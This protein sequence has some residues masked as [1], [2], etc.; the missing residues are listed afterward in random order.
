M[1]ERFYV[2]AALALILAIFFGVR[3]R[4]MPPPAA[5]LEKQGHG[6]SIRAEPATSR[7]EASGLTRGGVI[8]ARTIMLQRQLTIHE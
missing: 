3:T 5:L 8:N 4:P 1:G 6:P 7:Q 2:T